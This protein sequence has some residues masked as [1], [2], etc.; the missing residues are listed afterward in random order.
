MWV[1]CEGLA[2]ILLHGQTQKSTLVDCAVETGNKGIINGN[3]MSLIQMGIKC[4]S[5][6]WCYIQS[7]VFIW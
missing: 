2:R 7:Y 6:I 3:K 4:N 5:D 1:E